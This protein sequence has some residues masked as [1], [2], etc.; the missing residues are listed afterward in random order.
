MTPT[1][2]GGRVVRSAV[3][4]LVIVLEWGIE[5]ALNNSLSPCGGYIPLSPRG[6]QAAAISIYKGRNNKS[7]P[8]F[9]ILTCQERAVER[10]FRARGT[11]ANS[12]P[13]T[14]GGARERGSW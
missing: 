10:A 12:A 1:R 2:S 6:T 8:A 13:T 5:C 14:P 11:R 3:D 9:Q 4:S 7:L